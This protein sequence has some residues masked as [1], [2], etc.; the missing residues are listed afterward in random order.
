MSRIAADERR[1]ICDLLEELGPAADTLC[2]GWA[3]RDL[4]AHLVLR[5]H[6]PAA[7]GIRVKP[8]AGWTRHTQDGYARR[9]YASL[10]SRI[11]SGPPLWSP[12]ALP[13][14]DAA[15]N[16]SE[17]FVHHEDVRR[18][19]DG[20]EPRDLHPKVEDALWQVVKGWSR[21]TFRSAPTGVLLRRETGETVTGR[22][23]EPTVTVV[24]RPQE[25]LLY[26][27]GRKAHARVELEGDPD[28]VRA[29]RG[30]DLTV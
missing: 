21:I 27:M 25:V 2:E 18:A 9:P 12:F 30:E 5:E 19:Q 22:T 11:R 6:S 26:I 8:F 23:A 10:I 24:G 16:T 3:T 28:A 1:Q 20:W 15:I 29:L 17:Y 7:V 14:L 4:A 13:P